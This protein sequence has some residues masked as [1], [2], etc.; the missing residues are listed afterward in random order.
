MH[1]Q[2][3]H[4]CVPSGFAPLLASP[5]YIYSICEISLTLYC[6]LHALLKVVYHDDSYPARREANRGV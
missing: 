3:M 2:I 6:L 4:I 1:N 5:L